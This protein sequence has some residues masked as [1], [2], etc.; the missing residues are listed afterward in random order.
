[1]T[2]RELIVYILEN[3][4][5]DEQVIVDGE[6]LGFMTIDQAAAKFEVG[7]GTIT[8]WVTLAQIE[9]AIINGQ[10]YIPRNAEPKYK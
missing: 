6:I 7:K 9:Y 4:L 10:I 2:G 5:E 8:A 1:M 3:N